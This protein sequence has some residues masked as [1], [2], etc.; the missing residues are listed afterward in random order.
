MWFIPA[1]FGVLTWLAL[2]LR[3]LRVRALIPLRQPTPRH[4]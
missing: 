1:I 2:Y 4:A 3:D